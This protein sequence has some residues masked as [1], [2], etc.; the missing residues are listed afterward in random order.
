MLL[1]QILTIV[2]LLTPFYLWAANNSVKNMLDIDKICRKSPT[3]CLFEVNQKLQQTPLQSRVWYDLM[4]YKFETLLVLQK[5]NELHKIT[6][7]WINKKNIPI[8]FQL[9]LLI[10]YGKTLDADKTLDK[11]KRKQERIKVI[12]DAKRLLTLMNNVYPN[13]NLLIQFAN[14]QLYVGEDKKTYQLLQSL[15]VKYEN[16]PDLVFNA[17]L[18]ADLGHLA[19]RLKYK[20]QAITYWSTSLYWEKQLGNDQQT[21]LIYYNLAKSQRLNKNFKIAKANAEKAIYHATLAFDFIAQAQAQLL[22]VQIL[23]DLKQKVEA[24]KMLDSVQIKTLPEAS[25]TKFMQL[26]TKI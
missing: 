19:Y 3:D 17:N 23:L 7:T 16:Y 24:K 9:S 13:P 25:L 14:L 22:T 2:I 10:Y 4:Q 18:Y 20:E 5:D 11:A 1:R 8:P 12:D 15:S 21:A 26:K 6:K